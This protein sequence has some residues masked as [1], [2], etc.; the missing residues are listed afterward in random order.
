MNEH[1][2]HYVY[3]VIGM[4]IACAYIAACYT[5]G[6]RKSR[7]NATSATDDRPSMFIFGVR[8]YSLATREWE[9]HGVGHARR[10]TGIERA[11]Y[12]SPYRETR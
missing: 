8:Y 11:G 12:D 3:L 7:T 6:E 1:Y 10:M 9:G 5:I 4:L 2:V